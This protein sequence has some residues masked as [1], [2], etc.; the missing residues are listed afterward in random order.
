MSYE[1]WLSLDKTTALWRSHGSGVILLADERHKSI[2]NTL[3]C[4]VGLWCK[5]DISS[6]IVVRFKTYSSSCLAS[7]GILG[8]IK[9]THWHATCLFGTDATINICAQCT[10]TH[11]H[12]GFWLT[13]YDAGQGVL[14]KPCVR[15]LFSSVFHMRIYTHFFSFSPTHTHWLRAEE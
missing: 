14:E 4:T 15:D 11:T 8:F 5:I 3:C 9:H 13:V 12:I 1:F 10:H 7:C 6:A 2:T